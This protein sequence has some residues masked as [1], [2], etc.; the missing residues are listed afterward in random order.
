MPMALRLPHHDKA[1][2]QE[3]LAILRREITIGLEDAA[4]GRFSRKTIKELADEV[5]REHSGD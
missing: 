3:R 1:L 2:E 4:S 5:R